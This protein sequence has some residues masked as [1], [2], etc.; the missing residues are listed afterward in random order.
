VK[1]RGRLGALEE[2]EFRLLWLSRVEGW[3]EFRRQ[4]WIWVS[5]LHFGLF[6]MTALA[7]FFVLT[8]VIAKKELG[9]SSA[10]ATIMV[11]A[12]LGA[13]VGSLLAMRFKPQRQLVVAFLTVAICRSFWSAMR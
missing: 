3:S 9:G 1:L 8:P 12:G 4:T 6:H 10:Y 2:R 7:C 13:V 11:G 5:V